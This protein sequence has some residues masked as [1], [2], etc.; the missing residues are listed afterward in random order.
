M[1]KMKREA[2]GRKNKSQHSFIKGN[3][4]RD[5]KLIDFLELLEWILMLG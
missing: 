3:Y 4:V 1:E 5:G 2:E